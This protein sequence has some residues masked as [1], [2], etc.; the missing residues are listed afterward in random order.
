[1]VPARENSLSEV[2]RLIAR[3]K[4][5]WPWPAGYLEKALPLQEITTTYL[6]GNRCFEV[7]S[8]AGDLLAFVSVVETDARVVIDNLWVAPERIRRGIGRMACNHIIRLAQERGWPRLWV[9]PDPPA[10]GFYR[11]LGFSD[12]GER[13]PSRVS[14][15]PV[16]SVYCRPVE[17]RAK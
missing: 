15:G 13:V 7:I 4:S 16:F 11:A 10:E 8:N 17:G 2:N 1:M 3:S 6:R 5:Y 12:T 14:G 9:L